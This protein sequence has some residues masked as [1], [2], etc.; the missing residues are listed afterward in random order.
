NVPFR[1]VETAGPVVRGNV[2][3]IRGRMF[4]RGRNEVIAGVTAARE[5]AGLEVGK[6]LK[7]GKTEWNVVGVFSAGGGAA[8][9]ELWTDTTVLQA[10]YQ[11][12]ESYQSV[13]ARLVSSEQFQ[14]F[15]D[16]LPSNPHIKLKVVRQTESYADQS[17]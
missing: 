14:E 13:C 12:G 15:K 9:S 7:L 1:G 10:A 2:K 16:A 5:F 11:R 8:E 4:E 17:K 3:I 6:I